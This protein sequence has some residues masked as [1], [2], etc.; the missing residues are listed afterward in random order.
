VVLT[1]KVEEVKTTVDEII[2]SLHD[3]R[4]VYVNRVK[5]YQSDTNLSIELMNKE[6]SD[7]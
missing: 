3:F 2:K 1:K 7:L 6:L 5:K 4:D